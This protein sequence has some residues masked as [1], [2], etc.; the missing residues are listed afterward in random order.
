MAAS[1]DINEV[2]LARQPTAVMRGEMPAREVG[3]W[4]AD[5][6]HAVHDYLREMGVD[7]VG[8][9]FARLTFLAGDVVAE[10]GFPCAREIDGDGRVEPSALPAGHA[11]VATHT[12]SYEDLELAYEA[13]RLWLDARGYIEMGP[14]WELYFTD[15]Q[16][17][18]DPNT[19]RT[20]VVM[21]YRAA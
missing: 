21:P 4:L 12:G 15:P 5:C 9:P 2:I 20:D 7:P 18:A 16:A 11:A 6:Y 10:A 13:I 14:H 17:D 19:W 8:P 3:P 1:Y